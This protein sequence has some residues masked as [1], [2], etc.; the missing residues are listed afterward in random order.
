MRIFSKKVRFTHSGVLKSIWSIGKSFS[1]CK[2]A[3][4][5]YVNLPKFDTSTF[6]HSK[7]HIFWAKNCNL[8][9]QESS[10]RVGVLEKVARH[11]KIQWFHVKKPKI[12]R[13]QLFHISTSSGPMWKKNFFLETP[14]GHLPILFV[15]GTPIAECRAIARYVAKQHGKQEFFNFLKIC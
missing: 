14:Y 5:T 9:N 11:K 10:N 3:Q 6:T 13:L 2:N 12:S 1:P 7:F 15:D 4:K 8:L